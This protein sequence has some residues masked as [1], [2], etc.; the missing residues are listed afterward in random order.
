MGMCLWKRTT[1]TDNDDLSMNGTTTNG[2]HRNSNNSNSSRHTNVCSHIIDMPPSYE[3]IIN[4]YKCDLVVTD[5]V[6][7]LARMTEMSTATPPPTYDSL[8]FEQRA[9]CE[10]PS[11][12][13]SNHI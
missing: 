3:T 11:G 12:T 5:A 4:G 6:L 2:M 7:S 8:N 1:C 9:A 10:M 13:T